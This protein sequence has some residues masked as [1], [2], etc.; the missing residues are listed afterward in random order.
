MMSQQTPVR[1]KANIG[2]MVMRCND[3]VKRLWNVTRNIVHMSQPGYPSGGRAPIAGGDQRIVNKLIRNLGFL[4]TSK[5]LRWG[6]F[7]PE[8][9]TQVVLFDFN[10]LIEKSR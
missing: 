1:P 4:N 9:V 8:F 2:F 10:L 3:H 5:D 7:P 6:Y